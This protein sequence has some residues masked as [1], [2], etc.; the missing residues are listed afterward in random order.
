[1]VKSCLRTI[2]VALGI[3]GIAPG[4]RFAYEL[5]NADDLGGSGSGTGLGGF[6]SGGS[7]D[8][9]LGGDGDGSGDGDLNGD[10]DS[11]DGGTAGSGGSAVGA[12]GNGSGTI[13]D[14]HVTSSAGDAGPGTLRNAVDQ[15]L[16]SGSAKVITFDPGL[17]ILPA[18]T[19]PIITTPLQIIGNDTHV[20]FSSVPGGSSFCIEISSGTFLLQDIE[21][22]GCPTNP[23]FFNGGLNHRVENS[24]FHDNGGPL[25]TGPSSSGTV[26]GPGNLI[27]RSSSQGLFLNSAGD[28]AIDNR[29]LD[30]AGNGIFLAGSSDGAKI[31]GNLIARAGTGIQFNSNADTISIWFNTIVSSTGSAISVGQASALDVRNNILTHSSLYGINGAQNKFTQLSHNLYFSNTGGNCNGCSPGV[32]SL[33]NVDPLYVDSASDN[34]T[35]QALSQAIN[36]GLDLG[37]DRNGTSAGNFYGSGVDLGY[38]ESNY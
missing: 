14:Y 26:I 24:H 2:S 5:T 29:I 17:N 9:D 35:L 7:G 21:I 3:F 32:G 11:G 19:L 18:A 4:C 37:Q 36:A 38:M 1:M 6:S 10:G 31:I 15:A 8:G 34:F 13:G 12:G 27:E 22:S 16:A 20:D 25:T 30:T 23:I 33:E 28:I